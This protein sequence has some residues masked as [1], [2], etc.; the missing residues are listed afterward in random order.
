MRGLFRYG[1]E[2]AYDQWRISDLQRAMARQAAITGPATEYY[3]PYGGLSAREHSELIKRQEQEKE[4]EAQNRIKDE[5][6]QRKLVD[7]LSDDVKALKAEVRRLLG[8]RE[9]REKEIWSKPCKVWLK[10]Q[11]YNGE[12][13]LNALSAGTDYLNLIVYPPEGTS[14]CIHFKFV[15]KVSGGNKFIVHPQGSYNSYLGT[16]LWDECNL[17]LYWDEPTFLRTN[18]APMGEDDRALRQAFI[19][20]TLNYHPRDSLCPKEERAARIKL[21][22][23]VRQ[24]KPRVQKVPENT[25][26]VTDNQEASMANATTQATATA[27]PVEGPTKK[28]AAMDWTKEA[29]SQVAEGA[30]DGM[31][32]GLA[33]NITDIVMSTLAAKVP[34]VGVVYHSSAFVQ[35]LCY[36]AVPYL[37]GLSTALGM[38]GEGDSHE[39]VRNGA[40]RA[41]RA[42]A[43]VHVAPLIRSIKDPILRAIREADL[44]R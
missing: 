29:A 35:G 15:G 21:T 40:S 9:A 33:Q 44:R 28:D 16:L 24:K 13:I 38:W 4:R 3:N 30:K 34:A 17:W 42:A 19:D 25:T 6:E 43:T 37:V 20:Q 36:F 2:M 31:A 26:T 1:E 27:T 41:M 18:R 39:M 11:T 14:R 7:R 8:E 22:T 10:S 32:Y 5:T 12:G 23:A